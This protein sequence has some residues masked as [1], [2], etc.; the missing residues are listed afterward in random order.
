MR[1][2]A[3][4]SALKEMVCRPYIVRLIPGEAVSFNIEHPTIMQSV[5]GPAR[6]EYAPHDA[7]RGWFMANDGRA[8][9]SAKGG[10]SVILRDADGARDF[11]MIQVA[12]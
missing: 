7:F 8:Y 10:W 12:L 9:L 4:A 2:R 3:R 6:I 11:E 1:A 5:D